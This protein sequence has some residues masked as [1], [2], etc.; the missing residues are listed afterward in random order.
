MFIRFYTGGLFLLLEALQVDCKASEEGTW[1]SKEVCKLIFFISINV[2]FFYLFFFTSV[3]WL[4]GQFR[5]LQ[6]SI[7]LNTREKKVTSL[8]C[9]LVFASTKIGMR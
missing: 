4:R 2:L 7:Y 1:Y 9:S 8:M 5:R 6:H 3:S